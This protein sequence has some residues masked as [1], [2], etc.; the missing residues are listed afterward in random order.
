M[1]AALAIGFVGSMHCVGMCGPL[2]LFVTGKQKSS[3]VFI[4]YHGG[5]ILSYVLI[6]I[7]LGW[8]GYSIRMLQVQQVMTFTLGALLLLLYSIPHFRYRLE[9]HY[10]QSRF[11]SFIKQ[12]L[13]Q[14][15]STKNRWV[16]SGMANGFLPCGL[17]Y[18]AAVSTVATGGL[19]DGILF[20]FLFGLGTIP[21]LLLVTVVG[22]TFGSTKWKRLIPGAVSLVAILSGCLL[23]LRGLLISS[24]DFNQMVQAKAAG[25]ITVC[26][27]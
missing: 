2:A 21:A 4:L 1:I 17:T 12:K 22:R 19:A 16:A 8:L 9:K 6:G 3:L 5:R 24:P 11:Y 23:I 18:V 10:Y 26:G 20:M 13:S 14:N 7:V 15:I 27:L 25:L